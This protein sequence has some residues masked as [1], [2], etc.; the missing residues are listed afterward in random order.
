MNK[1]MPS[2]LNKNNECGYL[3][4]FL[5]PMFS[6]KTSKLIELYKQ[7]SFC[8]IPLAVINHSSDTRYDDTMLSTHDKIMI[9]CIQTS[10][11]VPV[12]NDMDNVD[13]ILINE[14]QFFEDLYDF[15]VDMLKFNKKIYV[16]GLDGDFKRE[17]F[18]KILDLIPLCDK[19]TKMTSLCGLCKNGSP[20]LFSMRLT[21]EK[22]Q[23]LIGSSNYIPVCRYC[24]EEN[25]QN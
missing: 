21:N 11:L 20:G 12:I 10:T 15:V 6:G 22:E 4:I 7:Y 8:N 24:Y 25:N 9:P 14:G 3:E 17:K 13:V 1:N 23:M 18:G 16:S 2:S 5:G 19:V